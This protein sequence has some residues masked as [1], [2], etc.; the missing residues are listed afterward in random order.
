MRIVRL[1]VIIVRL[2]LWVSEENEDGIYDINKV[3]RPPVCIC[4]FV[5]QELV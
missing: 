3:R 5:C 1:V 4:C 2:Q